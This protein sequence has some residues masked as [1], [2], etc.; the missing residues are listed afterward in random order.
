MGGWEKLAEIYQLILDYTKDNQL[1]LT[2][3]AYEEGLN[4]MSIQRREDYITVTTIPVR[5]GD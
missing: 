3:Y 5:G 4:E 1:T 2:G